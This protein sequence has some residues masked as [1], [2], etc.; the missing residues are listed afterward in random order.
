MVKIKQADI[1]NWLEK[2]W[3]IS[4]EDL[5]Q[6]EQ[7]VQKHPYYKKGQI[8]LAKAYHNHNHPQFESQLQRAALCTENRSWL[9]DYIHSSTEDIDT[10]DS[11]V[12]STEKIEEELSGSEVIEQKDETQPK[13]IKVKIKLDEGD[14]L[15]ELDEPILEA[16]KPKLIVEKKQK[17]VKSKPN[18]KETTKSKVSSKTKKKTSKKAVKTTPNKTA[19]KTKTS[20]KSSKSTQVS[21]KQE[22]TFLDWLSHNSD[23]KDLEDQE[24]KPAKKVQSSNSKIEKAEEM[25]ANFL[26]NKPKPGEVKMNEYDPEQKSL[27]SDSEEYIPVSETLARVYIE[28]NEL[29]LARKVY[30]KLILK[31]PE[32]KAY[33][34]ALIQKLDS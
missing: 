8:V 16:Q 6:L 24:T 11:H 7:L 13:K 28:Q 4:Q 12:T 15:K 26:A 23:I 30:D 21:K 33:F 2:G 14:I 1:Q 20:K 3:T 31:F 5:L 27:E 19:Q 32:K 29:E 9:Y 10:P 25:L 22:M 17:V 18:K 34:A